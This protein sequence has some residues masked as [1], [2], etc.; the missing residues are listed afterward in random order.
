MRINPRFLTVLVSLIALCWSATPVQ[1]QGLEALTGSAKETPEQKA[2]KEKLMFGAGSVDLYLGAGGFFYPHLEPGVDIGIIP[3]PGNINLSIGA[4]LDVGYCVSCLIT[5]FAADYV[6]GGNVDWEFRSWY[7]APQL[8]GLAHLGLISDILRLPELD[9]YVGIGAGPAMYYTGIKATSTQNGATASAE[10]FSWIGFGGPL[11]GMRF[12]LSDSFFLGVEARYF[13]SWGIEQQSVNLNG[14]V[15]NS[16][17]DGVV[18]D[19]YGTDYN[20]ALGVR[21]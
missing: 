17:V 20:L 12:M 15:Q 18:N 4:N 5:S 1:A 11:A 21:F 16:G 14:E 6:T 2:K 10:S 7:I 9:L 19:R 13:A 3:L 8:R